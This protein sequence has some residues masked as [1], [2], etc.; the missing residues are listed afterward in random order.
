MQKRFAKKLHNRDEVEVKMDG[1][2]IHGYIVGDSTVSRDGKFYWFDIQTQNG[3]VSG[4]S[5]RDLR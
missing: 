3:F 5:H 4:V 2:W 1:D